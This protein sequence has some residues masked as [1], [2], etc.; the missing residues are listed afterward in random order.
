MFPL[1]PN[2]K[3]KLFVMAKH[4]PMTSEFSKPHTSRDCPEKHVD[5]IYFDKDGK[6]DSRLADHHITDQ[7]SVKM[8]QETYDHHKSSSGASGK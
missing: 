4:S 1:L 8:G 2:P 5:R 3:P 7:G 6:Q